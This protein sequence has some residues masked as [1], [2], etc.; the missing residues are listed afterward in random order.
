MPRSV[1]D[2]VRHAGRHA[3][4]NILLLRGNL[5]VREDVTRIPCED[6]TQLVA[7]H[8]LSLGERQVHR[9]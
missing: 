5:V 1:A 9:S 2:G 7:N 6:L 8:I 3:I 4:G